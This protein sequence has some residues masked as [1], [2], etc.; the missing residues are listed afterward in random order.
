ME[1]APPPPP[2]PGNAD[3]LD[4][5]EYEKKDPGR[6][7][8]ATHNTCADGARRG[9]AASGPSDIVDDECSESGMSWLDEVDLGE[10]SDMEDDGS[11][12]VCRRPNRERM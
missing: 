8:R 1:Q 9:V 6:R 3:I 7:R 10:G 2:P 4:I 11:A 12:C 5:L